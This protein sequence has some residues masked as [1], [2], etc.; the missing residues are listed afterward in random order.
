M[1]KG[2]EEACQALLQQLDQLGISYHI[3]D[4]PAAETIEES[5]AYIAGMEGV[6]TK[7]LFLKDKHKRFYVLVM[8]DNKRLDFKE[9]QELTGAKRVSMAK[10]EDIMDQLGLV[11]GIISPFGLAKHPQ[12]VVGVYF[13]QDMLDEQIP[14]TFHPNV[15]THTIFLSAAD[16]QKFIEAQG[17]QVQALAL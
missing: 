1:L 7:S 14:L 4:H 5:D 6:P 10:D 16:L 2:S 12:D 3:V 9:F 8:D 13:D 17:Y 11:P 15:N